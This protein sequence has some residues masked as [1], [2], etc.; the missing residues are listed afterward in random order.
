[1]PLL[2]EH[3][4]QLL[5]KPIIVAPDKGSLNYAK[6][7]AEQLGCEFN[8]L[9][10]KRISGSEVQITEKK[11]DVRGMDVLMLDD[12][13]STGGTIAESSKLIDS[14]KPATLNVGCVHGLLLN[15]IEPFKGV[16]DRLVSTNTVASP[17][18]KVSVAKLIADDLKAT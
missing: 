2:V 11:L 12:I 9:A 18:A 15:G 14:W 7:A 5:V 8:H 13:I 17:V 10:K 3:F 1:M 6:K 16:V 4:R